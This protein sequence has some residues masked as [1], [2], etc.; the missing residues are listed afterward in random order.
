M[1]NQDLLTAA[2][3]DQRQVSAPLVLDPDGVE[4]LRL[5]ADDNHDFGGIQSSENVWL[6]GDAELV[7]E[8]NAAEEDF[9]AI[10]RQLL[11][12]V[13]CEDAVY[14]SRAAGIRLLVTD[15]YIEGLF[16]RRDVENSLLDVINGLRLVFVN[17]ALVGIRVFHG[18]LVILIGKDRGILR[19]VHSRYPAMRCGIFHV[20]DTIATEDKRPVCF[21]IGVIFIQNLLVDAHCTVEL[22]VPT[23]MVGTVIQVCFLII[24]KARQGLLGAA[25]IAYA[26]GCTLFEFYCA[27]AHF[28]FE[29]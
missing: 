20:F 18:G 4:V 6:E 19:T 21:S 9:E 12:E 15:E 10:P 13:V 27:A 17:G 29:N 24:I 22:V 14:G 8:G 1:P 11:I 23:E 25:A 3:L 26:D 28:A 16:F 5:G 7:L 2:V